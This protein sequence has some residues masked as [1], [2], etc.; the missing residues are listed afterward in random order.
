[1]TRFM[2]SIE[3]AVDLVLFAL[4][5]GH[6]KDLWTTKSKSATV[7]MIADAISDNQVII[8][9]RGT[10]KSGEALLTVSE[11]DHCETVHGYLRINPTINHPIKHEV[12]FTSDNAD[13]Y[14]FEEL[15]QIIDNT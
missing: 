7:G 1:M 8:G 5:H 15:K 11:L 3:N 6:D 10:E 4:E 14:S 2:I 13:R 12:P 9:T